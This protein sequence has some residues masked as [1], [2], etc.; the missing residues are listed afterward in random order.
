MSVIV[1]LNLQ[2]LIN[3]VV[4]AALPPWYFKGK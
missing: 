3:V 1:N 4:K 2:N